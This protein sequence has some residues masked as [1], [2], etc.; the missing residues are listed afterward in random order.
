[1]IKIN[2]KKFSVFTLLSLL[3]LIAGIAIYLDWVIRYNVWYDIGIYSVTIVLVL[4]GIIGIFLTL[5]ETTKEQ[6]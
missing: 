4:A 1:M 2:L 6:I 5:I 3:L